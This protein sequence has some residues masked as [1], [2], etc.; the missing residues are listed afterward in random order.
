MF[1]IWLK[2]IE[3]YSEITPIAVFLLLFSQIYQINSHH[4]LWTLC[5]VCSVSRFGCKTGKKIRTGPNW[6]GCNWT[7]GLVF[8]TGCR[9]VA[10]SFAW[11]SDSLLNFLQS[12]PRIIKIWM[13]FEWDMFKT[14]L[15]HLFKE[16]HCAFDSISLNSGSICLIYSLFW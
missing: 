6:T 16:Y 10:T 7:C 5:R 11:L 4:I 3:E 1:S 13:K 8:L 9:L 15:T 12:D 14:F 2:F